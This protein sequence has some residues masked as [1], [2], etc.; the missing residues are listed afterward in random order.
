MWGPT[1]IGA[2]WRQDQAG[3]EI[4]GR[5]RKKGEG[6]EEGNRSCAIGG[7]E[8]GN[9]SARGRRQRK[10]EK[11]RKEKKEK[12]KREKKKKRREGMKRMLFE[13]VVLLVCLLGC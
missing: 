10:Q 11:R 1:L 8:R 2:N 9:K 5:K 7:E 13:V 6:K 12:K 4:K 3:E